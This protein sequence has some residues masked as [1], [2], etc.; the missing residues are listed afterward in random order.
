MVNEG[1][2]VSFFCDNIIFNKIETIRNV[3][4]IS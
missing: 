2:W 1:I 3:I 4:Y